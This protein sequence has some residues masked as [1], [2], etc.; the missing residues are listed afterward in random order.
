MKLAEIRRMNTKDIKEVLEI[1]HSCF[2]TPWTRSAFEMEIKQNKLAVYFVAVIEEKVVGYGGMWLIM[3]EA[4]ITNIAVHP[5]YRGQKIGT[6]IMETIIQEAKNRRLLRMT[7]EVRNSNTVAQNLYRQ[8]G[9]L[10]CGIRPGY[11]Q[12]NGEDA[13]IMWKN[14]FSSAQ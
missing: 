6:K 5:K 13:L 12:D 3:D 9:F 7:L 14:L 4:H 11:Y 2:E 1:E 10:P 8:L